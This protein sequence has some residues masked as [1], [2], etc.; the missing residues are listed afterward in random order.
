MNFSESLKNKFGNNEVV[1][2]AFYGSSTTSVEYIFPNWVEIIR[3]VLKMSLDK[4]FAD[5]RQVWW[6]LFTHNVGLD[7]AKSS[8]LLDNLKKIVLDKNPHL[9]FI[10]AGIN[11]YYFMV[12]LEETRKNIEQI[13]KQALAS[14]SR[15]VYWT[16]APSAREDRNQAYETYHKV[17]QE[18]AAIFSGN[19]N[20]LF[21][22]LFS[23]FPKDAIEKSYTLIEPDGNE[24]LGLKPGEQDYV[25]FNRYGNA[26]VAKIL[27]KEAFGI[28]FEVEKFLGSLSDQTN[29]YPKF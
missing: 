16:S 13:I 23:I 29:K 22:D 25:H 10:D 9:I 1:D 21:V 3:Y 4:G 2:I 7:G 6:N 11:D 12:P 19:S 17:E 27:L 28:D 15:V 8:D 18:T 24:V 20:F 5:Y 14:G 26:V